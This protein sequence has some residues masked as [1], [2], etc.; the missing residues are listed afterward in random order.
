MANNKMLNYLH[1]NVRACTYTITCV[2]LRVIEAMTMHD[3]LE[4]CISSVL[5]F[6]QCIIKVKMCVSLYINIL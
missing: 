3:R 2:W 5:L 1:L 6:N 4:N